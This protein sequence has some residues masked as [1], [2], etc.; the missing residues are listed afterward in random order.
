MYDSVYILKAKQ[1]YNLHG[2]NIKLRFKNGIAM[3]IG[4]LYYFGYMD[5]SAIVYLKNASSTINDYYSYSISSE[6]E[7][8]LSNIYSGIGKLEDAL[9]YGN[10]ALNKKTL[11]KDGRQQFAVLHEIYNIYMMMGDETSAKST[12]EKSRKIAYA[13]NDTQKI[14]LNHRDYLH[15]YS[16]TGNNPQ[17]GKNLP[18]IAQFDAIYKLY[19]AWKPKDLFTQFEIN[20]FQVDKYLQ[21]NNF[22]LAKQYID[23]C[24]NI[25]GRMKKKQKSVIED[26]IFYSTWVEMKSNPQMS[27]NQDCINAI[28]RLK[29]DKQYYAAKEF[30]EMFYHN[31]LNKGEIKMAL[32][33]KLNAVAMNDSLTN[34][35]LQKAVKEWEK[36]YETKKKDNEILNQNQKIKNKNNNLF[37][38]AIGLCLL[39]A[40]FILFVLFQKNKTIREK[41]KTEKIFTKQLLENTEMERKRIA[42]DLHDGVGHELLNLKKSVDKSEA[43]IDEIL[44]EIRQISRNLHPVMFEQIGLKLSVEQLIST[45]QE[46]EQLFVNSTISYNKGLNTNDELQVY[47]IIQEALSNIKKYAQAHAANITITE[48]EQYFELLIEDNG[49]G[50]DVQKTL[51][52]GSAFGL[53]SIIQRTNSMGGNAEITSENNGT[54][55]SI[56]IP[57]LND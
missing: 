51:Q 11:L 50:F 32:D 38:M 46:K 53:F 13:I 4:K 20:I 26:Y 2:H 7:K 40:L 31:A 37:L 35:Q 21:E 33:Y 12:L 14:F 27:I 15:Y 9:A 45:F 57:L 49:K 39:F 5:D 30:Y 41:R 18:L 23:T 36:K 1:F 17:T 55:I 29:Q 6:S 24:H 28:D 10:S 16:V 54:K 19:T 44:S 48:T 34:L 52:S 47:R 42:N 22:V 3:Q 25:M 43:K 56:K 8:F